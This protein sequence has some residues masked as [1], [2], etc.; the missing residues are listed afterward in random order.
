MTCNTSIMREYHMISLEGKTHATTHAC[1][2]ACKHRMSAKA[3]ASKISDILLGLGQSGDSEC[4]L[5]PPIR[6]NCSARAGSSVKRK[7]DWNADETG[8]TPRKKI[9]QTCR[10]LD[11]LKSTALKKATNRKRNCTRLLGCHVSSDAPTKSPKNNG[12]RMRKNCVV[13]RA[14]TQ[15]YCFGCK[16]YLRAGITKKRAQAT[17]LTMELILLRFRA[18]AVA[19]A[20]AA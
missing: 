17:T 7:L 10:R 9:I 1:N 2:D 6:I 11:D 14:K 18:V 13:C 3:C 16:V 12:I 8:G 19:A 4:E 20:T 15:S 5:T